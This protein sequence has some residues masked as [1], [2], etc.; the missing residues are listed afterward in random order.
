MKYILSAF[1]FCWS[2]NSSANP[3]VVEL[4]SNKG[5]GLEEVVNGIRYGYPHEVTLKELANTSRNAPII[6]NAS[7]DIPFNWL[8]D[9]C[10]LL[11][12]MGF[13]DIS[14]NTS[15]KVPQNSKT[16]SSK[17]FTFRFAGVK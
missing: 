11:S 6:V 5:G 9:Y 10:Y 3:V 16:P 1:I 2:V 14:I 4:R 13:K 7:P 15:A 12:S 8:L 17:L